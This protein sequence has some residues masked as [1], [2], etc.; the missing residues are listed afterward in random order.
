MIVFILSLIIISDFELYRY[1]K[2]SCKLLINSLKYFVGGMYKLNVIR[3]IEFQIELHKFSN[4]FLSV[5]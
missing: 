4:P 3:I 1:F 2:I 5:T